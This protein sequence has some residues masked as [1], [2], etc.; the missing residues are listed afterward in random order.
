MANF[1]TQ[2]FGTA[3]EKSQ[4]RFSKLENKVIQSYG[5]LAEDFSW[6]KNEEEKQATI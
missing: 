6:R 2:L 4:Y 3:E 1:F 5:K